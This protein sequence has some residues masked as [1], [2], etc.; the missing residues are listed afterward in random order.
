M[1]ELKVEV[2]G[3]ENSIYHGMVGQVLGVE[4]ED[5][6]VYVNVYFKKEGRRMYFDPKDLKEMK[7]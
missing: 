4:K 3:C 6:E 2:V 7:K 1:K 5:E